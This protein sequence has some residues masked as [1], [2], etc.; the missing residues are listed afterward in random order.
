MRAVIYARYSSD[1][2]RDA[3]I[4]DQIRICRAHIDKQGWTYQHAYA[5]RALSG[6]STLRPAY[7]DLLQDARD[8]KFDVAV[9]EALD[10]FSRDQEHVDLMD[11]WREKY[12]DR[13]QLKWYAMLHLVSR[14][15][16]PDKLGFLYWRPPMDRNGTQAEFKPEGTLDWV[17][18]TPKDV[19]ILQE[20][21]LESIETIE[22]GKRQEDQDA[23]FPV[24]PGSDC[25]LCS[26]LD[27]CKEGQSFLT[28]KVPLPENIGVEDVGLG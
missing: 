27:G 15:T 28:K 23:A 6:A 2:Q 1:N 10:R 20:V 3:S 22:H 24:K 17:D 7:Q 13:R 5:D 14:G 18:C 12:V 25:R 16:L 21:V 19:S 8:G 4:D 26:Y 9:A 11:E